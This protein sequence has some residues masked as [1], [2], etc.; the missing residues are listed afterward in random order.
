MLGQQEQSVQV[1]SQYMKHSDDT[2]CYKWADMHRCAVPLLLDF[3]PW[4][5]GPF[6]GART[7]HKLPVPFNVLSISECLLVIHS[8]T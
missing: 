3:V 1:L 6:Y 2:Q 5:T 8:D 4:C 7:S